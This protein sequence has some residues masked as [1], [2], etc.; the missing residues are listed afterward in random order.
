M[1]EQDV[2]KTVLQRAGRVLHRPGAVKKII[3]N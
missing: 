2:Y 1:I 3:A